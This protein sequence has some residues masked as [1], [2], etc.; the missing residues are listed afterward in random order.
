[1]TYLWEKWHRFQL[2]S[3]FIG[4]KY[5]LLRFFFVFDI[6]PNI[7]CMFNNI[8]HYLWMKCICYVEEVLSITDYSFGIFSWKVLHHTIKL[9]QLLVQIWNWNFIISWNLN[10]L[11]LLDL[12]K[13]LVFLVQLTN[14]VFSNHFVR[15]HII[16]KIIKW[17]A[18]IYLLRGESSYTHK[19][20]SCLRIEKT[21]HCL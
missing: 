2:V 18:A 20:L 21:R 7:Q 16:L 17:I 4:N 8:L 6:K 14:E 10:E 13:L 3:P 12:Q 19:G 11:Y 5:W 9:D 15:R 1:M